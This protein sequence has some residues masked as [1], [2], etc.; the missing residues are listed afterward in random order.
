[1]HRSLSFWLSAVS[2]SVAVLVVV[3]YAAYRS[4]D[5]IRG[6][7]IDVTYP[8]TNTSVTLTPGQ[9]LIVEGTVRNSVSV[10]LNGRKIYLDEKAHFR[11]QLL[12]SKGYAIITVKAE[13]RYKRVSQKTLELMVK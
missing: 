1:M 3:G 10:H 9:P 5:F 4:Q 12:L 7:I 6:P 11:E 8:A 2:L 13:D